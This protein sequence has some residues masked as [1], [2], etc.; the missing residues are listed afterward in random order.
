MRAISAPTYSICFEQD[1]W[2]ALN[3]HLGAKQYSGIFVLTDS[4]TQ[5]HCS[6]IL[7]QELATECPV[8]LIEIEAGEATKTIDTCVAL[9][10]L[11]NDYGADRKSLLIN[12]GGGVVTD[13]GGFVAAT[14]KRGIDFIHV[15]TTLL[16]MVD[17]AIGGKNGVDLGPLKN[18]VGT[19]CDPALVCIDTRFLETLPA[20]Q[21]RSGLAEMLKHGLIYDV[22][23]WEIFENLELLQGGDLPL[24][25]HRSVE[26]KNDIVQSDPRENGM[27]RALNFGHTIGH[28]I[29][30]HFLEHRPEEGL[31]HGE[32]VAAGMI[33]EAH[34]SLQKGLLTQGEY[35]DI[36][37]RIGAIYPTLELTAEDLENIESLMLFDKKNEYGKILF[38]LLNGIG[39]ASTREQVDTEQIKL[40]FKD[41][42]S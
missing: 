28:A 26:I 5:Q 2:R 32:A 29:E 10:Q 8:E 15:P 42:K 22:R 38:A 20:K 27:R 30:G 9:W 33:V 6:Q 40:A 16:G 34:L 3:E 36:K 1:A 4:N 23:Y 7:L 12:L 39:A 11:L 19:I 37:K 41:Y 18:Q 35:D 13:L 14:F 25:V 24:L 31:L 21:M 17:A